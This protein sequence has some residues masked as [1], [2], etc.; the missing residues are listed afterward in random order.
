MKRVIALVLVFI[1]ASTIE[2]TVF[3]AQSEQQCYTGTEMYCDVDKSKLSEEMKI[4]ITNIKELGY[5]EEIIN[6]LT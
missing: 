4:A 5:S 3:A 1:M 6:D 2:G